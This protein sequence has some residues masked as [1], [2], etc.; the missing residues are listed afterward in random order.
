MIRA[1]V[2]Q[3]PRPVIR[4]LEV[5]QLFRDEHALT[6]TTSPAEAAEVVRAWLEDVV[7]RSD[8][9]PPTNGTW[10]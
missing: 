5:G 3:G 4:I 1:V 7:N 8:R 10:R 2:E 9:Q 6:V